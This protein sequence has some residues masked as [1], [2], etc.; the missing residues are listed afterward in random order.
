MRGDVPTIP[1]IV[2]S[3]LVLP[4]NLLSNESLSPDEEPEEEQS[5][6]VDTL[7]YNCEARLRVVVV[8]SEEAIRSLQQLLLRELHFLCPTCA[9]TR[10]HHGRSR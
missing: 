5:Y 7:C 10:C 8:A 4:A 2:L 6:R 1:D 9:R 3:S